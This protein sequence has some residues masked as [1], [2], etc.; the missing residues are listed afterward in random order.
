[1][2]SIFLLL[3]AVRSPRQITSYAKVRA[4]VG[5]L[6]RN[7]GFQLRR[8]RVQTLRYLD[9]GCGPNSHDEF[10]N[11]DYLWHPGIDVCWDIS[12]G[13]PLASGSM[14]GIFSEH[15]LEHFPIA[16][17]VEILRECRRVL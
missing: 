4:L 2:T 15:C 1:M 7:R 14:Q 16:T 12:R 9:V 13:I 17:A 3:R 5:K 8:Q 10:V 6:F 11:L